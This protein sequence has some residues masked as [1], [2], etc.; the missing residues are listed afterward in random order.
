[1]PFLP[2]QIFALSACSGSN[3]PFNPH[4]PVKMVKGLSRGWL[5][6]HDVLMSV[7][8]HD[9][10]THMSFVLWSMVA[11]D[12]STD[13]WLLQS[14]VGF[15]GCGGQAVAYWSG[16]SVGQAGGYQTKRAF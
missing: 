1:M 12:Q 14:A 3:C 13:S 15:Q 9:V 6:V 2:W 4:T 7:P 11:E 10:R 16:H 5:K 8:F